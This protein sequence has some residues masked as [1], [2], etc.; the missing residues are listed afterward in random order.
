M[1]K[2]T[3]WAGFWPKLTTIGSSILTLTAWRWRTQQF[4][5]LVIGCGLI[6]AVALMGVLPVFSSVMTTAGLRNVLRAQGNSSQII[7][8]SSLQ[9]L[10][11]SQVT[12]LATSVNRVVDRDAGQY[13]S[14]APQSTV[15]SGNWYLGYGGFTLDFYG[16]SL[17]AARSHLHLLQGQIPTESNFSTTSINILLTSSEALYL[18]HIQVGDTIPLATL[19]VTKP[20]NNNLGL[21]GGP[22]AYGNTLTAHVVGIFQVDPGDAFWDGYTLE[23][24]APQS[25][26]TPPP[27]LALTSQSDLLQFLDATATEQHVQTVFPADKSLSTLLLSYKL[28][29]ALLTDGRLNELITHLGQLQQDVYRVFTPTTIL[30]EADSNIVTVSLS[31]PVLHSASTDSTLEK[32]RSQVEITQTPALLLTAEIA[33]LLLFFVATM[34]SALVEREQLAMAVLRSR[35]S[36]RWQIFG[37]LFIQIL[38]LCLGAA[39]LGPAL[40][41]VLVRMIAPHFL[42]PTTGDA[43][44]AL[45]LDAGAL[46]R[47]LGLTTLITLGVCGLTSLL[48][49]LLAVRANI[50]T[51]RREEARQTQLPLW[52]RLRLDLLIMSLAICGYICI[53]YLEN[54]QGLIDGQGQVLVSTPLALLAP[55]LLVLAG[56]LGFLR[57]FP[58]LLKMLARLA[59]KRRDATVM[60]AFV[61]ME[62][63]PRQPMRVAL[64]LGL[65]TAFALFS[66][67]FAASQNQRPADLATYQAVSDFS[68]S[69]STLPATNPQNVVQVL[70]QTDESYLS[71]PG[72]TETTVGYVDTRYFVVNSYPSGEYSQST[73]LN[74]V[75]ADTFAQTATWTSQDSNE[76]LSTLMQLLATLRNP[77]MQR[78]V[79]P[80]IV[81]A[82]TWQLLGLS[83]GAIFHL[84]DVYGDS[85]GVSYLAL[86]EVQ[87]IPPVNDSLQGAILVDYQTMVAARA[88]AHETTSPNYLWLRSSSDPALLD[89]TRQALNTSDLALSNLVD[90]R[91]LSSD[92]AEDPLVND[93]LSILSTGVI[94]AFLLAFLATICLPLL[95]TRTRQTSFAVLRALGGK[96]GEVTLTL[97]WE[98]AIVLCT[99]LLLGLFFGL[100][101]AFTSVA[102]LV[103]TGVLPTN[104][105]TLSGT[106]I[107]LLQQL[108]PVRIILPPS[109]LLAILV[110]ALLSAVAVSLMSRVARHPLIAQAL[111]IDED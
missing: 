63:S 53:L 61:Q 58:L 35:G 62:R 48:T 103:F 110:Q 67:V 85:D 19:L 34:I 66:L 60:L 52:Q 95:N 78:G 68:G 93:L 47:S 45:P 32:Y 6:I 42:T 2:G 27:Y 88:R 71:I 7:A 3:V 108:L 38:A 80:T 97:V 87:H 4:L 104:L 41:V 23:V 54:V 9:G 69:T 10:S 31:G 76:S 100:L 39:L 94:V 91:A 102:P 50:L 90:R 36:S 89:Q 79:V 92:N 99:S 51:Q 17:E 15:I 8:T 83:P 106:A 72:I 73:I 86:A 101:L 40:A 56:I 98:L 22:E 75:D 74:A 16:V 29:P 64:L 44:N 65:A 30:E 46:F 24:Q 82:S 55:L 57:L 81:A 109:L 105:V 18:G 25:R 43:L 96:P 20:L 59:R 13:L 14:G 37:S 1:G 49:I 21:P 11:T 33:A 70:Q 77:S 84:T 26:E 28:N 107:Y 111:L 5:L 12:N